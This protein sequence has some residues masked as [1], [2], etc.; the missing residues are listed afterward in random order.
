MPSKKRVVKGQAEPVKEL[1]DGGTVAAA[2]THDMRV[3]L[4]SHCAEIDRPQAWVFRLALKKYL[5]NEAV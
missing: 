5:D 1:Y 4:D 3:K 2:L